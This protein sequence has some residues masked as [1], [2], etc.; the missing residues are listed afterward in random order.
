MTKIDWKFWKLQ[1]IK[2]YISQCV[3]ER[4]K[5]KDQTQYNKQIREACC[6]WAEQCNK[7]EKEN[8]KLWSNITILER[9]ID[10]RGRTLSTIFAN[11]NPYHRKLIADA[12]NYKGEKE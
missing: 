4:A 9:K 3:Y 2:G 12:L 1:V 8:K 11:C 10:K 6:I 5:R 7:L